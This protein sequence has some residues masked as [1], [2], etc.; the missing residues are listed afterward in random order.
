M[1]MNATRLIHITFHFY[2]PKKIQTEKILVR[3]NVSFFVYSI[4]V[5]YL[6]SFM[7]DVKGDESCK[8]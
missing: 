5:F 6:L 7:H 4:L 3:A 8:D 1:D 2:F